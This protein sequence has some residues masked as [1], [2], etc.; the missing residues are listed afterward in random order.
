[1]MKEFKSIFAELFVM[2]AILRWNRTQDEK[3]THTANRRRFFEEKFRSYGQR[4]SLTSIARWLYL[5]M[6][7]DNYVYKNTRPII[8]YV[9]AIWIQ[10]I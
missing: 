5:V 7:I 1:M 6:K 3:C 9:R 10:L 4:K 2:L 8:C